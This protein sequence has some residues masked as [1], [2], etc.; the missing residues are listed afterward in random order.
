M[1]GLF[2]M[3]AILSLHSTSIW[4][5]S[6]AKACDSPPPNSDDPVAWPT[7]RVKGIGDALVGSGSAW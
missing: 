2:C 4:V 7:G 1:L 3:V 6:V 5:Q